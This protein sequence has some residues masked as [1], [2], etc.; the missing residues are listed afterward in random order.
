MAVAGEIRTD[1]WAFAFISGISSASNGLPGLNVPDSEPVFQH[2][3]ERERG[4]LP[5][6]SSLAFLRPAPGR[7]RQLPRRSSPPGQ[8]RRKLLFDRQAPFAKDPASQLHRS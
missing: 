7:S 8:D 6:P 1:G 4:P 5:G 2:Q 3:A